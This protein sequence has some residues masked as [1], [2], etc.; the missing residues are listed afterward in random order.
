MLKTSMRSWTIT[1]VV[2]ACSSTTPEPSATPAPKPASEGAKRRDR[3][4]RAVRLPPRTWWCTHSPIQHGSNYC[5][6]TRNECELARAPLADQHGAPKGPT[7][8]GT[9]WSVC[10]TQHSAYCHRVTDLRH[11]SRSL[12]FETEDA[13]RQ[14][15]AALNTPQ[16]TMGACFK[17]DAARVRVEGKR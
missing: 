5:G 6:K 12:C 14:S 16:T 9:D 13:C 1:L 4:Q 3:G 7:E 17:F 11:Q 8:V 15:R 2:V 10:K